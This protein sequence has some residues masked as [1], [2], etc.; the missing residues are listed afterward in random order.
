MGMLTAHFPARH[1]EDDEVALDRERQVLADLA[2]CQRPL[3]VL[4]QGHPV[5]LRTADAQRTQAFPGGFRPT[6][7][8]CRKGSVDVTGDAGGIADDDRVR[9]YV[10]FAPIDA[11]RRT[12]VRAEGR[13]P[14]RLPRGSGSLVNVA[15]GPTNT[16]SSNVMP[17]QT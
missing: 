7:F 14:G 12:T 1:V 15:L 9:R 6:V 11:I 5:Q 16:S 10:A 13:Q 17:S 3:E 4:D 2:E 8:Q